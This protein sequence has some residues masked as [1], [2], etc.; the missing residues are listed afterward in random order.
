MTIQVGSLVETTDSTQG[1][2]KTWGSGPGVILSLTGD[3][4]IARVFW[5]VTQRSKYC[6]VED[7]RTIE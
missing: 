3:N 1:R 4:K 2:S 7:L 6:S 5:M